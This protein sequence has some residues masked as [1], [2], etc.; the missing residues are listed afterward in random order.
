[1]TEKIFSQPFNYHLIKIWLKAILN[2]EMVS[3]IDFSE[4]TVDFRILDPFPNWVIRWMSESIA[5]WHM[6]M[7]SFYRLFFYLIYKNFK[8]EII[9]SV[10]NLL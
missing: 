3:K 10:V 6:I 1:M 8:G 4:F 5:L 9:N 7:A 2:N